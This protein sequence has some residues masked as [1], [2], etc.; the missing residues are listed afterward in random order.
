[1]DFTTVDHIIQSAIKNGLFP[2][3]A[4]GVVVDNAILARKFYGR[5]AFAPWTRHVDYSSL[6]DLASLTKPLCT[7]LAVATLVQDGLVYLNQSIGDFF[8]H[9]SKEKTKITIQHLLTHSSGLEAWFPIY[10]V[11]NGKQSQKVPGRGGLDLACKLILERPLA[12]QTGQKALYSDLGFMLLA[13][14]VEQVAGQNLWKFVNRRLYLPLDLTRIGA[15][16]HPPSHQLDLF[17]P[18]GVCP[19]RKRM[20]WGEV[21]DLNAWTIGG[22]PGHA[23]L[24]SNLDDLLAFLSAIMKCCLGHRASRLALKNT[25]LGSFLNYRSGSKSVNWALGFDRPS[26]EFSSSGHLFSKNSVG[27]LGYT[28][29]SFWMDLDAGI[30][31]VFLSARTFPFDLAEDKRIMKDLRTC[32]HDRIREIVG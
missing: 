14:I 7:A 26:F 12:Y 15:F 3:A 18:T 8:Q 10:N 16:G 20:C 27:H 4:L 32:L 25:I 30:I 22:L 11:L 1:V 29:T 28:G 6:F 21:N 24:Y 23:G 19:V 31:V 9:I 5:H 13:Q 17:V 2:G